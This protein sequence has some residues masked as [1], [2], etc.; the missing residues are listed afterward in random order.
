MIG[1]SNNLKF[2]GAIKPMYLNRISKIGKGHL[3]SHMSE[4]GE[5]RS[6]MSEGGEP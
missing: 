2:L 6:P 4:G 5:V 1:K 3:R